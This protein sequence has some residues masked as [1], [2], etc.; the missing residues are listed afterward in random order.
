MELLYLDSKLLH[1]AIIYSCYK[2]AQQRE[3]LNAINFFPVADGDTGDN[4]AATANAI[5]AYSSTQSNLESTLKSIA[6]AAI[7][8]ARGNSG[9][10]FSQFFNGLMNTKITAEQLDTRLFSVLVINACIS[11]RDAILKPVDGTILTVME[12]WANSLNEY[13]HTISCFNRLLEQTLVNVENTLQST[14]QTL[15]IL[16]EA[17]VVDAGALGFSFFIKEFANFLANPELVTEKIA[18][19]HYDS[20]Q[21]E[22]IMEGK[23]PARRYCTEVV[24]V[25]DNIDKSYLANQLETMGDS[26]VISANP[27]LCRL[28]THSNKPWQVFS[29]LQT[30]GKIQHS[31]VDDML[32][33]YELLHQRKHS[34]AL[35]T[36]SGATISQ[37]LVDHYQIHLIALNVHLDGHDL[38]DK[39]SL[40][41]LN[42]YDNLATLKTYPSTSF[43]APALIAEKIDFLARHYE[44]ILIISMAQ[45]LSGTHDAIIKATQNH[46]NVHVINSRQVSG[47]QGLLVNHAAELIADG[48]SIEAIKKTLQ[49]KIEKTYLFIMVNQ[50]DSLIRSGRVGK[51]QGKFAQYS[52]IKPIITLDKEGKATIYDKAFSETKALGKLVST[53]A[54]LAR[55]PGID[56][57]CIVHAGVKEKAEEFAMM[58]SEAFG[59]EPV[60]IEPTST[61]IGLHAG[62]GCIALAAMMN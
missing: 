50:F 27:R 16:K 10:I 23:P 5:V 56:S 17:N 34:I 49:T 9:M 42:F 41:E 55:E 32:R 20:T 19:V 46:P 52:G 7:L 28:H 3:A 6:D 15:A 58:A 37:D 2:L 47:G 18:P 62:K 36:D 43:P 30:M 24:L 57:Y 53:V 48:Y 44:N 8:G 26:I 38:L 61:A 1:S 33:Q 29:L 14:S 35:V 39:Y 54:Q 12:S 51:L 25:A 21:H 31:K 45:V 13:T 60:F 22:P 4:L 59:H 40:D 11:V